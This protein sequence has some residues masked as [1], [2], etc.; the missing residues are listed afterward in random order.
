MYFACMCAQPPLNDP[1]H[2]YE[3]P[4]LSLTDPLLGYFLF[5][6]L[7]GIIMPPITIYYNEN[8]SVISVFQIEILPLVLTIIFNRIISSRL[9]QFGNNALQPKKSCLLPKSNFLSHPL[10]TFIIT[11]VL[12]FF[13]IAQ[14]TCGFFFCHTDKNL[15]HIFWAHHIL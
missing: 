6:Y 5:G 13:S 7:V 10:M 9:H 11:T 14:Y 8:N 1:P 2:R 12:I 3:N 15:H 4:S